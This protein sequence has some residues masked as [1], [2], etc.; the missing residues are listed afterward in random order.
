VI[1]TGTGKSILNLR[2]NII[3][4]LSDIKVK[5]RLNEIIYK[6]IGNEYEKLGDIFFDYQQASDSLSFYEVMDI[7]RID[8]NEIPVQVT[9]VTFDCDLTHVPTVLDKKYDI[10]DSLLF[11]SLGL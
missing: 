2:D 1:E 6:T 8:I 9:N 4:K 5:L 7:P 3:S 11:K 10:Q